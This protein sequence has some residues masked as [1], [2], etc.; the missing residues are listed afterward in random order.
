MEKIVCSRLLLANKLLKPNRENVRDIESILFCPGSL[1]LL[2]PSPRGSNPKSPGRLQDNSIAKK[3]QNKLKWYLAVLSGAYIHTSMS[4]STTLACLRHSS[5]YTVLSLTCRRATPEGISRGT[6]PAGRGPAARTRWTRHPWSR[7][8][9]A[10]AASS[11]TIPP[12][13]RASGE[14]AASGHGMPEC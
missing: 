11:Q 1:V 12:Q 4:S 8:P 2:L 3:Y 10:A 6:R 9:G 13:H 14:A 7:S 5:K